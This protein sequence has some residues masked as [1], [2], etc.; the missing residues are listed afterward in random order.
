M[1]R[2][3]R[4]QV[5]IEAMLIFGILLAI[6]LGIS[7]PIIFGSSHLSKDVSFSS[8]AR[9]SMERVAST[10]NGLTNENERRTLDVYVPGQTS[11]GSTNGGN[12]LVEKSITITTDSTGSNLVA[13]INMVRRYENDSIRSNET[14]PFTIELNGKGWKVYDTN[15]MENPVVE[16][17]GERYRV[18]VSWKNLTF[19][20]L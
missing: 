19:V 16:S 5:T 10:A 6:V 14:H 12:P 20:R 13:S 3:N 4:G 15:G 1:I 11:P 7:V 8:D 2:N 18:L 9:Y 17:L